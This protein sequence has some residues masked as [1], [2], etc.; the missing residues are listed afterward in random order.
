LV[1][2]TDAPFL[3]P[4]PL[5]TKKVFPNEPKNLELI[6]DYVAKLRG[7]KVE[8]LISYTTKNAKTLFGLH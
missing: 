8:E 2:E 6:A 4:E 7:E 5:R 1:L 3:T